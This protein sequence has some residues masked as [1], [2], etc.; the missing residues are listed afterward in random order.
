MSTGGN[1]IAIETLKR[2]ICEAEADIHRQEKVIAELQ[3]DGHTAI[4]AATLLRLLEN[5][6]EG[7]RKALAALGQ[8][9]SQ[10]T[11]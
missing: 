1:S 8:P 10:R 6:L 7:Y 4:G 9:P 3:R 2:L 5:D 11:G